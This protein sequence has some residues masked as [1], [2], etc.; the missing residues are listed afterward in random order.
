MKEAGPAAAEAMGITYE[1]FLD[2]Y[3]AESMIK[4]LNTVE[5]VGGDGGAARQSGGAGITGAL[6]NV[7]GGTAAGAR[8]G[9]EPMTQSIRHAE[10]RDRSGRMP[11]RFRRHRRSRGRSCPTSR[12]G[13]GS[14]S[15]TRRSGPTLYGGHWVITRF[16]AIRHALQEPTTFSNSRRS[17]ATRTRRTS[18]SRRSSIRRSTASTGRCTTPASPRAWSRRVTP[19]AREAAEP[20]HRRVHRR[21]RAATS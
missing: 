9:E 7:D 16:D 4:R 17:S 14:A 11:G 8:A 12:S 5:E 3:A 15:S 19:A 2:G 13:T 1:E 21:R 20:V 6:I 10:R 18:S